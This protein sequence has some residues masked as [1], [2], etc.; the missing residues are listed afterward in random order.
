MKKWIVIGIVLMFITGGV[1]AYKHFWQKDKADQFSLSEKGFNYSG[2]MGDLEVNYADPALA[3]FGVPSYPEAE[4]VD[5]KSVGEVNI[6]GQ[7]ILMGSFTSSDSNE[8]IINFYKS[9]IDDAIVG[10][11]ENGETQTIIKAP[12][13]SSVSVSTKDSLSY[14][15]I[16]K[17]L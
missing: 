2:E 17:P 14:I 8:K 9:K 6:S 12:N 16:V 3:D 4:P 11:V 7:K 15:V 5:D 13:G 10:T 1:F